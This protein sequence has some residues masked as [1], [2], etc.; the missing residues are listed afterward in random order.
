VLILQHASSAQTRKHLRG[1]RLR[2]QNKF[3]FSLSIRLPFSFLHHVYQE[4]G[5]DITL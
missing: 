5:I 1:K 2:F 3:Y 4:T